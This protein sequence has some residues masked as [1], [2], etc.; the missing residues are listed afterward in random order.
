MHEHGRMKEG[1]EL[2]KCIILRTVAGNGFQRQVK[3]SKRKIRFCDDIRK[4][5]CFHGK[6]FGLL[7]LFAGFLHFFAQVTFAITF[8]LRLV[9]IDAERRT[10]IS[11]V[12]VIMPY[13]G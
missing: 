13:N 11:A 2:F 9:D 7:F 4:Q 12:G 10:D 8:K 6:S 1:I 3:G 5:F